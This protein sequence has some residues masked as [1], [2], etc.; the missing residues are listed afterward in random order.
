MCTQPGP[1]RGGSRGGGQL[2]PDPNQVG[3]PNMRNI[4]KLNK[5]ARL[6]LRTLKVPFMGILNALEYCPPVF[7][8]V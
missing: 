2:A 8:L 5:V 4:L 7:S 3:A 6:H 1:P